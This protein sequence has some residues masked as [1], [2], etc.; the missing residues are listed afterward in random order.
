MNESSKYNYSTMG[1]KKEKKK[2][3]YTICNWARFSKRPDDE[4]EN[5]NKIARNE[6]W[7]WL[8]AVVFDALHRVYMYAP[9]AYAKNL[10]LI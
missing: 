4:L 6:K 3:K 9:K 2:D 8:E 5:R 10:F 7:T 1:S